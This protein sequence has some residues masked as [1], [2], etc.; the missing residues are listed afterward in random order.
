MQ[1]VARSIRRTQP[2]SYAADVRCHC[3][4][5]YAP[6]DPHRNFFIP[7]S[8]YNATAKAPLLWEITSS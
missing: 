7:V 8:E 5:S 3:G 1:T 6:G 2:E 4:D